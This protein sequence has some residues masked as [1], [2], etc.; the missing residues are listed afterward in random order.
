M[1]P[2]IVSAQRVTTP[3]VPVVGTV[4]FISATGT[5]YAGTGATTISSPSS[6]ASIANGDGLFCILMARSAVTPPSGWTLVHSYAAPAGFEQ[7]VYAYRKNSVSTSDS[8]T[9]FVWTQASSGRMGLAY[10]TVRSTTGSMAVVQVDGVGQ[11]D[12]N[13]GAHNVSAPVLTATA[14]GELFLLAATSTFTAA[15]ASNTWAAPSGATLRTTAA[16]VENRLAAATH[17]RNNGESNSSPWTF[18]MG[19]SSA[20][21]FAAITIR[22]APS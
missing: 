4:S 18:T 3:T 22:I 11:A 5:S 20:S 6:P 8:S 15:S 2:G 10:I 19:T 1:I 12:G 14:D 7:K 17:S 9:A 13:T 16:Q 21:E